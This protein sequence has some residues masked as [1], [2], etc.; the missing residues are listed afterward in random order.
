MKRKKNIA[1]EPS[2]NVVVLL[3]KSFLKFHI[4]GILVISWMC[5]IF[6]GLLEFPL[7]CMKSCESFL[8]PN[9]SVQDLKFY[10]TSRPPE[11]VTN[12]SSVDK[13]E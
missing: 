6:Y 1:L 11:K 12:E 13:L 10:F 3:Y 4:S 2:L 8:R 9:F 5:N 7:K